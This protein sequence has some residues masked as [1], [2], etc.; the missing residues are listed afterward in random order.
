M[1]IF[2]RCMQ[3]K[4]C[5]VQ[6][7]IQFLLIFILT[8]KLA[9]RIEWIVLSYLP[10]LE[11]QL[12]HFRCTNKIFKISDLKFIVQGFWEA[13]MIFLPTSLITS[14]TSSSKRN[15]YIWRY[16]VASLKKW[17]QWCPAAS[18]YQLFLGQICFSC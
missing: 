18:R 2:L 15:G 6:R 4:Y 13:R 12:T 5:W 16:M 7:W 17:E 11:G 9:M 1:Q 3:A 14:L 10:T 8:L